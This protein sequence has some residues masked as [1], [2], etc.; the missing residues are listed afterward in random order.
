MRT[1]VYIA[2]IILACAAAAPASAADAYLKVAGASQG[3]ITGGSTRAGR[4]GWI[5]V[6]GWSHEIA[7]PQDAATG[8]GRMAARVQH[9]PLVVVKTID[10]ATPLLLQAAATNESLSDVTLDMIGSSASGAQ[11][12]A[13]KVQLENARVAGVAYETD[14]QGRQIEKVSFVYQTIRQTHVATGRAVEVNAQAG[15][16]TLNLQPR[17]V[18]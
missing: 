14:A 17:R 6:I 7:S 5:E 18:N 2:S 10:A 1:S 9:K 3:D 15:T 13:F 11:T 16:S 8:S 12:V 4:E